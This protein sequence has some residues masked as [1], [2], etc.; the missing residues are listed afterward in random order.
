[1]NEHR[2]GAL[3]L[4]ALCIVAVICGV[5]VLGFLAEPSAVGRVRVALMVIGGGMIIA[6][7]AGAVFGVRMLVT[8]RT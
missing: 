2:W 1:M 3:G 6:G 7:V 4:L 5:F 8:R